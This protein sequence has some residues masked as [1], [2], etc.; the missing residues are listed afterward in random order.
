LRRRGWVVVLAALLVANGAVLARG[1]GA[2]FVPRLSE[3][4]VVVNTVRLA[5]VDLD[6]SVRYG[7]QIERALLAAFPDEILRIWTRTGTAEVATDPMGVELSDVFVTLRPRAR[8]RRARSQDEL[9]RAMQ[10]ALRDMPGMRTVFTQPIEMRVNEMVAGIRAD[11]GIKIFGDDLEEL[12]AAAR[13]VDAIVRTIPGSADVSVE[14]VT[15]LPVLRIELDQA[16]ASR[17]GIPAEAVLATVAALAG[18]EVAELREGQRRFPVAVRIEPARA[19]DSDAIGALLVAAPDGAQV[20]LSQLARVRTESGPSTIQREWARRRITVQA[21]VRGR[22]IAS[23]VAEARR[24]IVAEARLAPGYSVTYGGQFEH[25]ERARHRL[26][27]VVPLALLL[28]FS[29]LYLT[30]GRVLDAL[31]VFTGVPFAALGGVVALWLRAMPFS[32]SAAVGFIAVSGVAVLGDMVLASTIRRSLDAGV[33]PREAIRAA[34]LERLRPVL[35]T[36][37]VAG[38]G[39]LPMALSRGIGAEVQRPLAT[40]VLGG[41]VSSTLLTLVVLPALYSFLARPQ[42]V[43]DELAAD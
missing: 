16:A 27:F 40:V 34:A 30:Y 20:P 17:F 39:F 43:V 3:G 6:E 31:R 12:R 7:T 22:D 35:M 33:E 24:R 28:V 19:M 32:I 18:V 25:L 14:Q 2:E 26:L 21:N 37:L 9:V 15:G 29:L 42:V 8:W 10:A 1:L 38:L 13:R 4:T 23:F 11:L 36:A 41:L 5:S